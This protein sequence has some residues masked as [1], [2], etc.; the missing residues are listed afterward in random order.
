MPRMKIWLMATIVWPAKVSH[1]WVGPV[2]NTFDTMNSTTSSSSQVEHVIIIGGQVTLLGHLRSP[3]R[4]LIV[5]LYTHLSKLT[6]PS[7]LL[8][9]WPS[10][11][12]RWSSWSYLEPASCA[13]A[14]RTKEDAQSKALVFYHGVVMLMVLMMMQLM[15]KDMWSL[16]SDGMKGDRVN[17]GNPWQ[18]WKMLNKVFQTESLCTLCE[19][20]TVLVIYFKLIMLHPLPIAKGLISMILVTSTVIVMFPIDNAAKWTFEN[21]PKRGGLKISNHLL[22]EKPWSWK[23]EWNIAD[24]KEDHTSYPG[25]F[26]SI[27]TILGHIG[28]FLP[29]NVVSQY[30]PQDSVRNF[31]GTPCSNYHVDHTR[32]IHS[33]SW[34]SIVLLKNWSDDH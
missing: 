33:K 21:R 17:E 11:L 4:E 26:R 28:S 15:L 20:F 5:I 1:H 18:R 3:L 10:L 25:L 9:R 8:A 30:I 2:E 27:R 32:P 7:S 23:Y 6:R 22:V 13:G 31:F 16:W 19:L 14:R 12:P 24:L 34:D 29:K